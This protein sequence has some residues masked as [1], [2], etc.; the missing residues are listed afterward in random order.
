VVSSAIGFDQRRGDLVEVVN[1]RF[2]DAPALAV[3]DGGGLLALL[4][5]T[6]DDIMRAVEFVVMG[7]L[8]LVVVL[9]VVRPLVRRIIEPDPPA[10]ANLVQ[11]IANRTATGAEPAPAVTQNETGKMLEIAKIS[12][13]LQAETVKQVGEL[14]DSHPNETAIIREW[15]SEAASPS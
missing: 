7:I 4:Q 2:A 12:G 15:L 9:V 1:L 6:K 13:K 8:G 11:A 3:N 5:F 10:A 14:G